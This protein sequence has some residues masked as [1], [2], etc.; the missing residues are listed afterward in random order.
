MNLRSATSPA[1]SPAF[2]KSCFA[3]SQAQSHHRERVLKKGGRCACRTVTPWRAIEHRAQALVSNTCSLGA[4][5]T[6]RGTWGS[7]AFLRVGA[8][9]HGFPP[10]VLSYFREWRDG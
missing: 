10:G 9:P 4:A 7:H 3:E 2:L 5:A 8:S 6:S 1:K